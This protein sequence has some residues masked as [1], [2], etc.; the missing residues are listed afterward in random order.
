MAY[1][2]VILNGT[3]LIDLTSDTVTAPALAVGETAHK[4][5]GTSI[6]GSLS[7]VTINTPSSGTR[8]FSITVPNGQNSTITFVFTVDSSGNTTVAES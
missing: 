2:K 5:D 4:N 8:S 1:S 6:T 3:T 7:G